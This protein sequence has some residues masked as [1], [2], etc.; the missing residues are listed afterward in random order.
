MVTELH[1]IEPDIGLVH[2]ADILS[3]NN[4]TLSFSNIIK[5]KKYVDLVL[6]D[7]QLVAILKPLAIR[8]NHTVHSFSAWGGDIVEKVKCYRFMSDFIDSRVVGEHDALI[9]NSGSP[10]SW[11][12]SQVGAHPAPKT[13]R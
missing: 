5:F 13:L 10:D 1:L 3:L 12:L 11:L 4:E 6:F 9:R 2:N 7:S 8:R